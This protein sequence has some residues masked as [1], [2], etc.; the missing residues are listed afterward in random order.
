MKR[1][2]LIYLAISTVAMASDKVNPGFNFEGIEAFWEIAG[3]LEADQEPTKEQW[4]LFFEAPGYKAL[5]ERE[6][7]RT[8]FQ[9]ALRAIFMPSQSSLEEQFRDEYKQKGG[10]LAWYTPQVLEGFHEADRD[11]EWMASR[12]EELKSYPYLKKAADVALQYLPETETDTYPEVDFIVFNDSRG[13]S[14]LIIGLTGKDDL[15]P[16]ELECL[17]GQ[18]HD[19][20]W[21]FVLHMAHESFHLY[22]DRQQ[23]FELPE[24]DHPDYPLLWTLD[25]MENEG[26]GDLINRKTLYYDN[27]CLAETERASK[28]QKEQ[29]AQPATLRIMD[30]FLSEMAEDPDLIEGLGR[31]LR[32]FIPQ[33]GHPTGFYM[34]NL[35]EKELGTEPL[36]EVVR[37][38]FEFFFL[39][40]KAARKNG[41][42][43][44]FSPKAMTLIR[45]LEQKYMKVPADS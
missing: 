14:P 40:N 11:R 21:P 8:Y 19:H 36:V 33:S 16:S 9:K 18:G 34:A 5:T 2:I 37:N 44:L 17:K 41:T 15:Q 4:N 30:V 12:V 24:E 35:I 6:F 20:H 23:E 42:A 1:W 39:Y 13:Y 27:G 32:R 26:I 7:G 43:P 3:I 29:R 31:Q 38:P 45:S 22:R 28:L 10:F 25:Q